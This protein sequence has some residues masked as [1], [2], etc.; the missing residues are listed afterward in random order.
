M[1]TTVIYDEAQVPAYTLPD[2]LLMADG[3]PVTDAASWQQNRRPELL[4]IF[5]NQVYGQ[6]PSRSVAV[7]AT[8]TDLDTTALEGRATRKQVTLTF[9][10]AA[11][12]PAMHLLIYAPNHKPDPHPTFLGL[13]FAGNHTIHA[14]PGIHLSQQ[15]MRENPEGGVVDHRATDAARGRSASRWAVDAILARGYAL[16]TSYYGD[17]D[18]DF[19]DGFQNGVHPLFYQPG[20]R[21]PAAHEWGSLGAW[22]WGLSRA[23]DYFADERL[24]DE[25]RVALLGHSRLG[26]A[27]LWAGAQDERFALVI[28]NDS[29]CGGAA[30]S[31]RCFGET[32]GAI[33]TRFPHWFCANFQQYNEHEADLP[34]DQ[35]Q[36][37]A[38]I[39]PRPLY[40]ASAAEDLWADP[41]GEFL[42]AYHAGPVYTLFGY[43]GIPTAEMP[44]IHTPIMNRIGYHIRAGKHDVTDYDWA[45]FLDFADR[46]WQ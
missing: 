27:T 45:R 37:L 16:V 21:R 41:R 31:R 1:S 38:L 46:Y 3:T 2:P 28:S 39:A 4:Q 36:L 13:N 20:Q 43:T 17:L 18:P 14:D 30:L 26:K 10:D 12:G 5:A 29:G 35:H 42:S 33:N 6:T 11:N 15:W 32:V 44:P 25:Q 8:V 34:I 7:Q 23:L 9:G 19:D 40:V 22:A 24:I